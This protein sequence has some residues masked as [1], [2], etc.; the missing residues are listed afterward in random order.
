MPIPGSQVHF[1]S[2]TSDVLL[3]RLRCNRVHCHFE[4]SFSNETEWREHR[5]KCQV[6][7]LEFCC[8]FFTCP[9]TPP[10]PFQSLEEVVDHE[11]G[12]HGVW[13][14]TAVGCDETFV[15]RRSL[16]GHTLLKHHE[17]EDPDDAIQ[18]LWTAR[19]NN[20]NV[21][22]GLCVNLGHNEETHDSES[23]GNV[24]RGG[25][26]KGFGQFISKHINSQLSILHELISETGQMLP[27]KDREL[28]AKKVAVL[29][30]SLS[31]P[32][33]FNTVGDYSAGSSGI[34]WN[35]MVQLV[36]QQNFG[37]SHQLTTSPH[38]SLYTLPSI[39]ESSNTAL[40]K[41][42]HDISPLTQRLP[43]IHTSKSA[44]QPDEPEESTSDDFD[45]SQEGRL[46][47]SADTEPIQTQHLG[48][49]IQREYFEQLQAVCIEASHDFYRKHQRILDTVTDRKKRHFCKTPHGDPIKSQHDLS[50]PQWTHLLR[51][52]SDAKGL[53]RNM[54]SR[55]ESFNGEIQPVDEVRHAFSKNKQKSDRDLLALVQTTRVFCWQLR[56]WDKCQD[57][58][59]LYTTIE[60]RI[61]HVK[62]ELRETKGLEIS[63]KTSRLGSLNR[64]NSAGITQSRPSLTWPSLATPMEET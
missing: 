2:G 44:L 60:Q 21:E 23:R 50:L 63:K 9:A 46:P 40:P 58:D 56:D 47:H 43:R 19:F 3:R 62:K 26:S 17:I 36:Q 39:T 33:A 61:R 22:P 49:A 48:A 35:E 32:Q 24:D 7:N 4:C 53:T 5:A 6:N 15:H 12:S 25:L 14:C 31:S 1:D 52:L 59:D 13:R 42:S 45:D 20:E 51:R 55:I 54:V 30:L 57:L 41:A 38:K 37:N 18:M 29:S 28:I 64:V 8:S 16:H 34:H 27:P 11:N 10:S